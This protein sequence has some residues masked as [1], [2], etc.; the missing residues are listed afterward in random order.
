MLFTKGM[1]LVGVGL[2]GIIA[3]IELPVS[4]TMAYLFINEAVNLYQWI[5]I[6]LIV[7]AIAIMN[8]SFIKILKPN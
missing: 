7:L 1:P 2:G 8:I 6:V 5:G 3:S 4:V